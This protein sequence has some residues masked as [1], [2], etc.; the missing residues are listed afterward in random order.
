MRHGWCDVCSLPP[1]R[2]LTAVHSLELQR[3]ALPRTAGGFLCLS[4]SGETKD[5]ARALQLAQDMQLPTF[6]VINAVGSLL[7]RQVRT[8]SPRKKGQVKGGGGWRRKEGKNGGDEGKR[9]DL[10]PAESKNN[11]ER[12]HDS[13]L[14]GA[15]SD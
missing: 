7:A 6:S 12:H 9:V 11:G 3:E 15:L 4:Q 13:L 8:V 10:M 2:F 5:V 14:P 1:A